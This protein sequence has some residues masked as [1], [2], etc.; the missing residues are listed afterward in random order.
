MLKIISHDKKIERVCAQ[1]KSASQRGVPVEFA[2]KSVSHFVPN[3]YRNEK[4]IPKIDLSPLDELLEIDTERLTCTAESGITFSA[5]VQATLKKG[6]IPRTVSELKTI[7]IGGA[8][9][10]CSIESMSYKHGGFHDS[11][12]EYEVITGEGEVVTCS[13]EK[14]PETFHM[15]HGSYGTLGI[16]TKLKFKLLKAK[17]YVRMEYRLH[18]NFTD[19]W[20][21]MKQRCEQDDYDFVDGIIH[22]PTQF[23]TCL[24][25][26]VDQVPYR[27]RYDWLDIFYKSALER[28]E[29]YMTTYDYFFRYD[30][31]CH[32][33][34]ETIPPLQYKPV[35][36]LL[37]KVFLGSTNLIKWSNRLR[38]VLKLKKR[39]DVVV[40]VF[41]P[42][43]RFEEFYDWYE[44]DFDFFPLWI[45]PY[46]FKEFYPWIAPEYAKSMGD[47]FVIDCAVYGKPNSDPAVDYSELMER[48]VT[49]LKGIKTLISRN[50][51]TEE[52]FWTIYNKPH[53]DKMKSRLDPKGLFASLYERFAPPKYR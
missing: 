7:T 5:L 15:M 4:E 37:G 25:R 28:R 19:F 42:S 43:I 36:F 20:K 13:P 26:M 41:I 47:Q 29:D 16:L 2:K 45:V 34:T 9:S 17:P 50:H 31:E 38:H 11:C 30:A 23:V 3:P 32:W 21:D 10:G 14:E 52:E 22:S 40:D 48:K 49:E 33:L 46:Q 1:V 44:R 53:Y 12:L 18:S 39:P 8:V 35:R 27:S 51:Y 6:L 24:G